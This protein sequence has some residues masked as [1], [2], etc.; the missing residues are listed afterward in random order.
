MVRARGIE[1]LPQAW[2]AHV[3]PIYYARPGKAAAVVRCKEGRI[4]SA[5]G[6]NLARAKRGLA[7]FPV[8][9]RVE[10]YAGEHK[11][12]HGRGNR[13]LSGNGAG[14]TGGN[15]GGDR[16]ADRGRRGIAAAVRKGLRLIVKPDLRN[17]DTVLLDSVDNPMLRIDSS[18][19]VS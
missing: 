19:P 8:L 5:G 6:G 9:I 12:R 14:A 7:F 10:Y 15:D 2:E 11:P 1:P 13:A 3:L 16:P 17:E 4:G 18:G